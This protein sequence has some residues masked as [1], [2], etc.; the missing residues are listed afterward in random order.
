MSESKTKTVSAPTKTAPVL[1]KSALGLVRVGNEMQVIRIKFNPETKEVGA[2]EI[3]ATE[4]S[5]DAGEKR[6]KI[7]TVKEG[8]LP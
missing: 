1:T 8:L 2:L 5:Q 6:F 7:F 3:I 4:D